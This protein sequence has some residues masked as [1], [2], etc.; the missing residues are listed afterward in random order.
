MIGSKN[1]DFSQ[2]GYF[3]IGILL[4]LTA[5]FMGLPDFEAVTSISSDDFSSLGQI[6]GFATQPDVETTETDTVDLQKGLQGYW[7]FDDPKVSR[8]NS[9]E[10]D[11][12]DDYVS[13]PSSESVSGLNEITIISWVKLDSIGSYTVVGNGGSTN[14]YQLQLWDDGR[15]QNYINTKSSGSQNCVGGSLETGK[16]HLVGMAWNGTTQKTYLDGERVNECEFTGDMPDS[17]DNICIGSWECG[18]SEFMNGNFDDL[19]IYNRS[20]SL[21]EVQDL[22]NDRPVSREG[23]VLYQDFNGG[24]SDCDLTSNTACLKDDSGKNNDGTPHNFDDNQFDTESGWFNETPLNRPSARDY[25]GE[26]HMGRIYGGK[27]G[28]LKNF[29]FSSESG[30]SEGFIGGNA[31][32]LD[33]IDDKIV[34]N[35]NDFDLTNS[36]TLAAWVKP[37]G[38]VQDAVIYRFSCGDG[39]GYRLKTQESYIQF[40]LNNGTQ[41][42]HINSNSVTDF[43]GEWTHQAV[44]YSDKENKVGFYINGE[45]TGTVNIDAKIEPLS[46]AKFTIGRRGC[47]SDELN[48]SIDDVQVY[49]SAL[50]PKEIERVY[51]G[52]TVDNGLVAR[53]NFEA[54][55]RE[56]AYD[57]SGLHKEGILGSDSVAISHGGNIT[58]SPQQALSSENQVSVST[59]YRNPRY[60]FGDGSDGSVT[61]TVEKRIDEDLKSNGRT[62]SD[63]V[64]YVAKRLKGGEV[65][66]FSTPDGIREGDQVLVVNLQG[67]ASKYDNVGEYSFRRVESVNYSL[68]EII[69]E[70]EVSG[71]FGDATYQNIVVQRV[72]EYTDLT[73]DGGELTVSDWGRTS[74]GS[75]PEGW[76]YHAGEC[77]KQTSLDTWSNTRSVCRDYGGELARIDNSS[78]NSFIADNFPDSWI[79]FRDISGP[80]HGGTDSPYEWVWTYGDYYDFKNFAS[81]EPSV[82]G[83]DHNPTVRIGSGGGWYTEFG[84]NN[85]YPGVCELDKKKGGVLAFETSGKLETVNGGVINATGKGYRGGDC[86]YCGDDADGRAGEGIGG[87]GKYGFYGETNNLN[88][89]AGAYVNDNDG[90]DPAGGGGYGTSGED[91]NKGHDGGISVGEEE[92]GR[93]YFGGGGGTGS[94][95]DYGEPE[96]EDSHGGGIVH[97]EARVSKDLKIKSEGIDGKADCGQSWAAQSGGGAGGTVYLAAQDASIQKMNASGGSGIYDGGD[98][99]NNN[100]CLSGER[101]GDGGEGRIR[102]NK[103]DGSQSGVQPDPYDTGLI[104]NLVQENREF[105]LGGYRDIVYGII[106]NKSAGF[107]QL[108]DSN[109]WRNLALSFGSGSAYLYMNGKKVDSFEKSSFTNLDNDLVISEGLEDKIDELRLYNRSLSDQ[110]VQR[111]AFR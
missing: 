41:D 61:V 53:W 42:F 15:V 47:G 111:L 11:G 54:G 2:L 25:S 76:T 9:L 55:N 18:N 50:S 88:G 26:R 23:L 86:T 12:Q 90:G 62:Y 103:I 95:N 33:G 49:E 79:G 28:S 110:E 91:S 38:S 45:A 80:D 19:R 10:F 14:E 69:L 81:G 64:N 78:V 29:N 57:T 99:P 87:T 1:R 36:L 51:Q 82:G 66:T 30:W 16:W 60:K 6:T 72:P 40:S 71:E 63:A 4:V 98:G 65:S 70:N 106:N 22:Y 43:S 96:P 67:T 93:F 94:D 73:V 27:R 34:S 105:G 37:K 108:S 68:N 77:Y 32:S 100:Q 3:L 104:P 46:N 52:Q 7:R 109:E 35:S 21:S 84:D 20:L 17:S 102:I 101:S 74:I 92:L 31:L 56:T 59:W 75:C 83:V 13:V 48:G 5:F 58:V 97:I 89:G 85:T 39:G 24:P 8:G 44:T 107:T